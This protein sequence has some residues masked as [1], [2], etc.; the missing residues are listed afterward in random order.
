MTVIIQGGQLLTIAEGTQVNKTAVTLPA[1]ATLPIFTVSGGRIIVTSL[2]AEITTIV[3]AQTCLVKFLSTPTTGS[4]V[5]LCI[6]TA[7]DITGLEVG[8]KL[9][10][11]PAI[12][13]KTVIANAGAILLSPSRADLIAIGTIGFNTSATNTGA[14]KFS[15]TYIPYDAGATVVAA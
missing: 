1:T 14:L 11:P 4:A 6:A 9:T 3:Q 7:A 8:G 13:T 2:V 5:D 12:A 10:L 15:M